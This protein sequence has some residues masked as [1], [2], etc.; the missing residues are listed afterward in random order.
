MKSFCAKERY[1]YMFQTKNE[2]ITKYL[3]LS[4]N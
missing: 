3:V 1:V 2:I 4:N